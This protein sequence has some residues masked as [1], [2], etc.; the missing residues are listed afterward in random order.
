MATLT[1]L[2]SKA[3][4]LSIKGYSRMNKSQLEEAIASASNYT[5]SDEPVEIVNGDTRVHVHDEMPD[6][7]QLDPSDFVGDNRQ[8]FFT[9]VAKK[10][11]EMAAAANAENIAADDDNPDLSDV[12]F[13]LKMN[14][15][16]RHLRRKFFK[17]A[18]SK[19]P[20]KQKEAQRLLA[21][22]V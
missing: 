16:P 19:N 18:G 14:G 20:A 4:D 7:G 17:L 13:T 15:I 3:K 12:N 5:I 6:I 22:F 21:S 8:E 2:K 11:E 10:H 9:N 1:E